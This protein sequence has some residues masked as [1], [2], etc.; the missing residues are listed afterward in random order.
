MLEIKKTN[1][2]KQFKILNGNRP[3]DSK[4]IKKLKESIQKKDYLF[5]HPII[6]NEHSEVIDGQHRLQAAKEL[7]LDIYYIKSDEVEADHIVESNS[8]Q[9]TWSVKDFINFYSVRDKNPDYI[10]LSQMIKQSKLNPRA[11]LALLLGT[12]A[13]EIMSSVKRGKFKMPESHEP[14]EIYN[15]FLDFIAYADDKHIKPISMFNNFRFTLAF[16]WLYL[17]DGFFHEMLIKRLDQKWFELKPQVNAKEWY[18]LLL[19]IYNHRNPKK[20]ES[21][22][23]GEI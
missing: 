6:V 20:L 1:N 12:T 10:E 21:I 15:F 3:I 2:H 11:L 7:N 9:L 18:A 19:D 17:T 14:K 22:H 13:P 4:H 23:N 8:N 16:R 5:L